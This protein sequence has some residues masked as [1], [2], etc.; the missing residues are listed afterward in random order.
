M[1][2]NQKD[3]GNKLYRYMMQHDVCTK[4][5]LFNVLGWDKSKD[6][7]LRDL[8]SMIA[9]KVPVISTSDSKGYK[10]AKSVKDIEEVKHQWKE[11]D[12]RQQELEARKKPLIDFINNNRNNIVF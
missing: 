11:I 9:K 2:P 6:R 3:N 4:E 7:Q 5:E 8:I 10:I 12:K 1:T